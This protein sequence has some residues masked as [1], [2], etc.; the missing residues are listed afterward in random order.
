MSR[1]VSNTKG[2]EVMKSTQPVELPI[3]LSKFRNNIWNFGILAWLFGIADRSIAVIADGRLLAVEISQLLTAF[4]FFLCWLYLKPEQSSSR[5]NVDTLQRYQGDAHSQVGTYLS[6]AQIRML[7]LQEQHLISQEYVLP[8]PYLCQIYH[9]L[10]LKHLEKIHD[11][12]LNSLKV[13]DVSYFQSTDSGGIVKFRT[14]LDSPVNPLR[15]WRQPVVEVGLTLH[16]PYT[17][18]LSIP[19]YNNKKI[20]VIFNALPLS[21]SEHKFLVDIYS[22]LG[23]P[24]IFLQILLH[25]AACLTL[26]EDLPYLSRLAD[27]NIYR[28]VNLNKVSD[29]KTMWL[30]RRFVELY[31]SSME[32]TQSNRP[33]LSEATT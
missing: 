27:R 13:I 1:K 21:N 30:Y 5:G 23:W 2:C 20:V 4:L 6:T 3:S 10:N 28:L 8:V 11:F 18:E 17:V 7:E 32:L 26:F 12:S 16:T 19:V 22:D 25:A 29:H 33:R 15:I 31:G 24:K 14:V 9:L